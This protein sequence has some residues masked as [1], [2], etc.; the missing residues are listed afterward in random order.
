[1]ADP[2]QGH[3]KYLTQPEAIAAG[4]IHANATHAFIGVDHFDRAPNGRG[5]IRLESKS[6]YTYGLFLLDVDHLPYGCGTW[7]A[8]WTV[9]NLWP[10]QGEIDIIEGINNQENNTMV[11]H[12]VPDGCTCQLHD[13]PAEQ[14]GTTWPISGC[15]GG[16]LSYYLKVEETKPRSYGGPGYEG[17]VYAMEWTAET[18]KVWFFPRGQ[19]PADAVD[20]QPTPDNWGKPTMFVD[21]KQCALAGKY[22]DHKVIINTTFCGGWAGIQSL[23]ESSGCARQTGQPTCVDHVTQNPNAFRNAYWLVRGMKVWQR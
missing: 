21:M 7:P 22:K 20:G 16:G 1:G 9:G 10:Q 17:G 4:R 3:V 19:E 12:T 23:W 2:T 6:V 14:T 15:S 11:V 5:S 8:W 18:V 13:S